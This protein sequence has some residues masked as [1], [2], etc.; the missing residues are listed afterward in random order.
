SEWWKLMAEG[1]E[2]FSAKMSPE[3]QEFYQKVGIVDLNQAFKGKEIEVQGEVQAF[4]YGQNG[5]PDTIWT[6]HIDVTSIDQVRDAN[7]SES[8]IRPEIPV[9][10]LT[11]AQ[12][13]ERGQE[14]Y[15]SRK[16]VAVRFKVAGV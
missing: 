6:Y 10:R 12:A 13:A 15:Y 8:S 3:V 4:G 7:Q 16:K 2:E 1:T 9:E 11:A 5:R 14:L